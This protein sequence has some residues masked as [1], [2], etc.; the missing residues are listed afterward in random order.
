[1]TGLPWPKGERT[2]ARG[3]NDLGEVVGSGFDGDPQAVLWDNGVAKTLRLRKNDRSNIEP[4]HINNVGHIVGRVQRNFSGPL[5]YVIWPNAGAPYVEV[6]DL[7]P[8]QS[9]WR[10]IETVDDL[11][12]SAQM[13]GHGKRGADSGFTEVHAFLLTPV[14]W[15]FTLDAPSPGR[16]GVSNTL[17]VTGVTPGASVRFF[18]DI[19]GGGT[20]IPGCTIQTNV[21]QLERPTLIGAAVADA[22]GVASITRIVP[23]IAQN[24]SI[25]F[26][27]V[28]QSECAISQLVVH[29]FE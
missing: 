24:K 20:I 1:M 26:Q 12:D 22:N 14:N 9:L 16:A 2:N 5:V 4:L 6:Q 25:L 19:H 3:M 8:P 11:N 21:L 7:L 23:P 28:V 10:K 27:A 15:S 17:R 13:V 18:Y 29:E